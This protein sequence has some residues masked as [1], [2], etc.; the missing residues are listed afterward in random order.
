MN[1]RNPSVNRKTK[2]E[3]LEERIERAVDTR[4]I[5][6]SEARAMF[7]DSMSN[8]TNQL[9]QIVSR[10]SVGQRRSN[11]SKNPDN[12]SDQDPYWRGGSYAKRTTSEE[13]LCRNGLAACR[14]ALQKNKPS[15]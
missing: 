14:E 2:D 15:A 9:N 3:L 10:A 4:G 5:S 11:R 7:S 1:E 6:Y 12:D 8:D 13:D